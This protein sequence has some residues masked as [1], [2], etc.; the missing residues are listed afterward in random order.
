MLILSLLPQ[1]LMGFKLMHL[2]HRV[3]ASTCKQ[4]IGDE[5]EDFF[6]EGK[7]GTN[8]LKA[9]CTRINCE[10]FSSK[11]SKKHDAKSPFLTGGSIFQAKN[12]PFFVI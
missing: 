9:L 1:M 5:G 3:R 12:M 7:D 11:R 2:T 10:I 4:L 8:G 6:Y